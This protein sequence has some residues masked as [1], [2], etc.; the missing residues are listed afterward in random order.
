VGE[1]ARRDGGRGGGLTREEDDREAGQGEAG[2]GDE[3]ERSA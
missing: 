3:R 2:K 1:Q